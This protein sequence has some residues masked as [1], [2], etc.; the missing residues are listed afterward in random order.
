M[1]SQTTSTILLF[2][3]DHLR[4]RGR[5]RGTTYGTVNNEFATPFLPAYHVD[6]STDQGIPVTPAGIVAL[7][8]SDKGDYVE[9]VGSDPSKPTFVGIVE[10]FHQLHC[11]VSKGTPGALDSSGH[12]QTLV[13]H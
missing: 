1:T 8:K 10:V 3:G 13:K 6:T 9:A 5:G 4:Q 12:D 11:L 2:T 7:N